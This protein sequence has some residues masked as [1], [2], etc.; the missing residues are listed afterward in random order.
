MRRIRPGSS[1]P[2]MLTTGLALVVMAAPTTSRAKTY[3]FSGAGSCQLSTP[4]TATMVRARANGYRNEGATPQLVICGLDGYEAATFISYSLI[5][6]S[7]DG[8]PHDISCT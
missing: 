4:T 8:Q 3:E 2:S 1:M 7:V 5:F 6:T